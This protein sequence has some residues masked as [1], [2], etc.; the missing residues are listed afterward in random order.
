MSGSCGDIDILRLE[1]DAG[2]ALSVLI[3]DM[4]SSTSAK[5]EHRLQVA[6][7]HEMLA[8]VLR[9]AGV[10][11]AGIQ[12]GILYRG[13]DHEE[14]GFDDRQQAAVVA[15]R[16]AAQTYFGTQAGLLELIERSVALSPAP[17]PTWSPAQFATPYRRVRLRSA[18]PWAVVRR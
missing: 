16:A 14:R 15:Q 8:T 7:Y 3:A 6:F 17:L 9:G 11:F 1:R 5:V 18:A 12:I 10:P 4:K 13:P 2:G